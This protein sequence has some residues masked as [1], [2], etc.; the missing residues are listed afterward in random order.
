MTAL[1]TSKVLWIVVVIM[2]GIA[3]ILLLEMNV[4]F[5]LSMEL[6]VLTGFFYSSAIYENFTFFFFMITF[7]FFLMG[8]EL[9]NEVF[10]IAMWRDTTVDANNHYF[11]SIFISL[12]S[13]LLAYQLVWKKSKIG[14]NEKVKHNDDKTLRIRVASKTIF[15]ITF[16]FYLLPVFERIFFVKNFSYYESYVS[17]S[18][19]IPLLFIKIGEMCPASFAI[20]LATFPPKKEIKLP[21]I[22]YILYALLYILTGKR[23]ITISS[24]IFVVAYCLLRNKTDEKEGV[25]WI[26]KRTIALIIALLP[27]V[28]AGL[29]A[30]STIRVGATLDNSDTFGQLLFKLFSSV[31]DSDRVIKYGYM[32]KDQFPSGHFYT[33][34]NVIDYFKYGTLSSFLFGSDVKVSQTVAY[35][36]NGNGFSYTLSYLY[37]PLRFLSGHGLGSCYIGQLYQDMGYIGIVVGNIVIGIL[38]RNVFNITSGNVWKNA[39]LFY[40]YRII[41]L[42]PRNDFDV[43]FRELLSVGFIAVFILVYYYSNS[44]LHN[45]SSISFVTLS[46]NKK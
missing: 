45:E 26:K 29:A 36:L 6:L 34:G 44:R 3:G 30:Y 11:V 40:S 35:A 7:F 25:F 18:T 38:L 13:L 16:A 5:V 23:F 19:N 31:G 15:F 14:L 8:G 43:V 12:L 39:V 46:G 10:D 37:Y 41:L 32:F 20:Y 42:V 27:F 22:C 4:L 1:N 9:I 28:G 33:L 17:Y 21:I 24:I 2:A